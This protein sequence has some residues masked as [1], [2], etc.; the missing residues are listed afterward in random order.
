VT[1]LGIIF[2]PAALVLFFWRPSYLVPLAILASPFEAGSVLNVTIGD[3]PIGIAPFYFVQVCITLRLLVSKARGKP[4]LPPRND[5]A[6]VIAILLC[7]FCLWSAF[8]AFAMPHL[9]AGITVEP[10]RLNSFP[11][12]LEWSL[13]NFAQASYL[14]LNVGFVLYALQVVHNEQQSENLLKAFYWSV[15]IAVAVGLAQ[16]LALAMH[17]E[18]PYEAFNNNPAYAQGFEE[19]VDSIRRINS[20]FVEPSTAG[21]FLSAAATGL[22]A[23]FL[24][25]RR[26]LHWLLGIFVVAA[27]LLQTTATTGL[28]SVALM[29]LVLL[30]FF[31]P[32]KKRAKFSLSLTKT[33][34]AILVI[35]SILGFVLYLNP[36]LSEAL[37]AMTVEKMGTESFWG[38]LI[39]DFFGITIFLNTDALGAGLG[40]S[41]SSSLISTL[42]STVGIIGTG[43]FGAVLYKILKLFP[44]REAPPS[45][46]MSFWAFLGLFVAHAMSIPDINRPVLW[47]LLAIL[48]VHL[49]L[50]PVFASQVNSE[51]A[52]NTSIGLTSG[53]LPAK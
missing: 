40:S 39:S 44:G 46:Q 9:F 47:S 26:G 3:F 20:T 36:D 5:P 27:V 52:E 2:V 16:S 17:W 43:L 11:G 32:F 14:I 21:S 15:F 35:F 23:S 53:I 50:C 37:V 33:W 38:R 7:A 22:I 45:L 19:E 13:S 49:N 1:F 28:A 42:L 30:V 51:F 31:N 8:S 24:A 41:R 18:F 10:P 25:G 48:V 29:F 12:P 4:L 34:I 6:W